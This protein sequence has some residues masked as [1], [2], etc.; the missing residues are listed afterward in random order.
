MRID[1]DRVLGFN[2]QT[3]AHLGTE[4]KN[5][6]LMFLSQGNAQE[7]GLGSHQFS[8]LKDLN[9]INDED[10]Q[11][12]LILMVRPNEKNMLVRIMNNIKIPVSPTTAGTT[13][14]SFKTNS[15]RGTQLF[16]TV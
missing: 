8:D 10:V 14:P 5:S 7:A 13:V 4:V 16:T 6:L 2:R 3:I 1:D 11:N 12:L 9:I 15:Q